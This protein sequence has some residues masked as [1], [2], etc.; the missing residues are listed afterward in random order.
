MNWKICLVN[1]KRFVGHSTPEKVVEMIEYNIKLVWL[2]ERI[3]PE[4]IVAV[5][6]NQEYKLYDINY[7]RGSYT[8]LLGTTDEAEKIFEGIFWRIFSYDL[9]QNSYI[10]AK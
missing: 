6:N 1:I 7:L 5:M 8:T 9:G 4:S 10:W 2:N 3:E